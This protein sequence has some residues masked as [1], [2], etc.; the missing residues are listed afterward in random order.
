MTQEDA[1]R[2]TEKLRDRIRVLDRHY[3][4]LDEP[5]VPDFEY[6]ELIR[7][8]KDLEARFPDLVTLDSPTQRV[9]GEP[10]DFFDT[11]R[12]RQSMLSMENTYN[13]KELLEFDE[14]VRKGTGLPS[15][16]ICYVVEFK[17]DG[18]AVRLTYEDGVF[19]QGGTRGDGVHGEDVTANLR[20]IKNLPL[21]LSMP[22][23]DLR[24]TVLEVHGE[25]VIPGSAFHLFNQRR[26]RDGLS[27]FA[28]PR[29]AAAGSLKLLDSRQT[30]KRPLRF[31]AHGVG[32][33]EGISFPTHFR[34]IEFLEQ[35][36][37]TVDSRRRRFLGMDAVIAWTKQV[38]RS[39][40]PLEVQADGLVIKVNQRE[41]QQKLGSTS[42]SPRW[43]IAYKFASDQA[44]T[45]L[46]RIDLQVGRTGV[47]TPVAILE[48][49]HLA[50][51][52]V[53]RATLHNED[54]LSRLG[55]R[56]G[57]RVAI[58][59]AGEIIPRVVRVILL[60]RKGEERAF[61]VPRGCPVCLGEAVRDADGVA[62]RCVNASCS[63]QI[64]GRLVHYASRRAMDIEGLG[65]KVVQQLMR[66]GLVRSLS[67]LYRLN[68]ESLLGLEGFGEK[69]ISNLLRG[70]EKSKSRGLD[71]FLFG[72]G[73]RQIGIYV[74]GI[75][76]RHF[77]RVEE[78]RDA[79]FA[80][81]QAMDSLGPVLARCVRDF[82]DHPDNLKL[83]DELRSLGV[84]PEPVLLDA[85]RE[86]L[87]GNTFVLTGSMKG[88]SRDEVRSMIESRGGKV[89][90]SVSGNTTYLVVGANPGSKL[91]KAEELGVEVLDEHGLIEMLGVGHEK[92]GAK[93]S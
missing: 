91:R 60:E 45:G 70:I 22:G 69:S 54:E 58:E 48:P 75:L 25:V 7:R 74:A 39:L 84:F 76:A 30:A 37:L 73:I 3:Y 35:A 51:T 90:E 1:R 46:K 20:T 65:K 57:D 52:T 24:G 12:H 78:L 33:V 11:V 82:F 44:V 31:I 71:R 68:R 80:R 93:T 32:A 18:L 62:V 61:S 15:Q 67:D 55:I 34:W 81:L 49:V 66:A 6:D 56:E 21:L 14:R 83:L 10:L 86:S 88:R 79:T 87:S 17:F 2:E 9:S 92:D 19:V 4:D 72:L 28:N 36:G 50:G 89:S 85:N 42:K 63:A 13:P 8:L 26:I 38:E 27:P 29:N 23:R 43:Q 59:K 64:E 40:D 16:D 41:L 5:V 47:L 77:K 53:S